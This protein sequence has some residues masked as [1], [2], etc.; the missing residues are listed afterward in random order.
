M[1][2]EKQQKADNLYIS[3]SL[4]KNSPPFFFI[5]GT[6]LGSMFNSL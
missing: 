3:E 2:V 1:E 5:Y 6:G 4:E